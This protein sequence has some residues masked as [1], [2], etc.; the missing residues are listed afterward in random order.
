MVGM[1]P[2]PVTPLPLTPPPHRA[3]WAGLGLVLG[4]GGGRGCLGKVLAGLHVRLPG[5]L[6]WDWCLGLGWEIA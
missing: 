2:A 1:K 4:R 6:G 5:G 3:G